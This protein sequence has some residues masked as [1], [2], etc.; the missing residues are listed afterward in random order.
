[1]PG[2]ENWYF[3]QAPHTEIEIRQAELDV[4]YAR[5]DEAERRARF[6]EA[7]QAAPRLSTPMCRRCQQRPADGSGIFCRECWI[8]TGDP[9]GEFCDE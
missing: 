2:P 4:L 3:G 9:V 7:P 5:Q 1:M 6:D 8:E